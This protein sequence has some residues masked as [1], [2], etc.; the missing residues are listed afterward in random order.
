MATEQRQHEESGDHERDAGPFTRWVQ[1]SIR[2]PQRAYRAMFY[3]LMIFFLL[4]TLF[5]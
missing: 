3:V 5:P 2:N 1:S 4:T